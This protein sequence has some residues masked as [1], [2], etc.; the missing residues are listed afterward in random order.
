MK[1]RGHQSG[2]S[3]CGNIAAMMFEV[4]CC[5]EKVLMYALHFV[6]FLV[7]QVHFAIADS[8][9]NCTLQN[10]TLHCQY[11]KIGLSIAR[12]VDIV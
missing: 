4:I 5:F 12:G 1:T 2:P 7:C 8:K 10:R 6:V 3:V 11:R 9:L